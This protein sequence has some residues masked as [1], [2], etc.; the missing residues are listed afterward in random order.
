MVGVGDGP[1]DAMKQFDDYVPQRSFDNFQVIEI[2]VSEKANFNTKSL[3]SDEKKL[4]FDLQY[5]SS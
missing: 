4:G 2:L 1:W 3:L 5:P